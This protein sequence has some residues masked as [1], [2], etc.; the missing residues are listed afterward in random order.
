MKFKGKTWIIEWNSK[1]LRTFRDQ[2][3]H[4]IRIGPFLWMEFT[5]STEQMLS[6]VTFTRKYMNQDV[7][8]SWWNR[9]LKMHIKLLTRRIGSDRNGRVE[10]QLP[11]KLI[12]FE[13]QQGI[14][15]A[16]LLLYHTR[17]KCGQYSDLL[18]LLIIYWSSL[19]FRKL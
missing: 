12:K 6:I 16:S 9:K 13:W 10:N 11:R 18:P 7:Q 1:M 2:A 15:P 4:R 19:F 3:T 14:R 8:I 17:K 5:M